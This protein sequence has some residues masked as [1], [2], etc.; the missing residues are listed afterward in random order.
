MIFVLYHK[1]NFG[2]RTLREYEV[3]FIVQVVGAEFR[4]RAMV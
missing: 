3:E 2:H 1:R 4:E